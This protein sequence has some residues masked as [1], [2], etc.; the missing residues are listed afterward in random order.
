MVMSAVAAGLFAALSGVLG[1]LSVTN[2]VD[3]PWL[4]RMIFFALNPV[5]T[6]QMWRY[7]LK[8]LSV[9]PTPKCQI[10]NA[11][12]NFAASA[13]LGVIIFSETINLLWMCGAALVALGL[14]VIG[15]GDGNPGV[16]SQKDA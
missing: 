13:I 3:V 1:K 5:C 2:E 10:V 16:A 15:A 14:A 7:Y 9:A 4:L 6:V 12:T 11:G 8:A